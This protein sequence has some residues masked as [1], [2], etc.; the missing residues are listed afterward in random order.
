MVEQSS[1]KTI[2]KNTIALYLRMGLSMVVSLYTS[3]VILQVLGVTDM[4]LYSAVGGIVGFVGFLNAALSGGTSRFLTFALGKGDMKEMKD[5]FTTVFW[6][7]A[8][9]AIIIYLLVETVGLWFLYNKLVIPADRMDAAV[10]VF[11]LSALTMLFSITQVPYGACVMAHEKMSMYAYTGI[12]E[13]VLKLIIVYLLLITPGDK[14]KWYASFFFATTM[15]IML[16][17]RWYCNHKFEECHLQLKFDKAIFKPIAKY[18]GWQLFAHG[19]IALNGQGILIL[20]NMFFSP[21]VVAARSIS[22][23]VNAM[24]TQFMT[25]F[26]SAANPQIIK[27][28]AAGDFDGSRRLLLESTK[29]C[30]YL[31]LLM[32]LPIYLLSYDLLY[33]WLGQVP[34]YTDIFLKLIMIQGLF[35]IFDSGLY[36]AVSAHGNIRPNALT[37]PT[38]GFIA[39]PTTFILFKLGYS[40]IALSWIFI[41]VYAILGLIQKPVILVKVVGY[42]WMDFIPM[43]WSCMKVTIVSSIIPVI[44]RYNIEHY[45]DNRYIVFISVAMVSVLSV[46]VTVWCIGLDKNI[47]KKIIGF[48]KSKLH[49]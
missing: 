43:Y 4:G 7:H 25:N 34:E 13:T 11:H 3:R 2:A 18:S 32:S 12:V 24:A 22:L 40:P 31:M 38:I 23:Q 29:Y 35:S 45:T 6:V 17:Y 48:T 21:A 28:Y 5:T 39:F 16:F 26:R 44:I 47:R 49:K 46:L 37:S 33:L 36:T 15:G 20:L 14:L 8:F 30:Y 27:R 42:K 10:W 9:L 41:V 19:A 1:N